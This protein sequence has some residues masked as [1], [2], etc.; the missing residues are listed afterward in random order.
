MRIHAVVVLAALC[1]TA[2]AVP[3]AQAQS[4]IPESRV[5]AFGGSTPGTVSNSPSAVRTDVGSNVGAGGNAGPSNEI[6]TPANRP[7]S[8]GIKPL[9]GTS[10][11]LTITR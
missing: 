7:N 5:P 1:A 10:G 8:D 6:V 9:P 11:S 2:A 3:E 4:P